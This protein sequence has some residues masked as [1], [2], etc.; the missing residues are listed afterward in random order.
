VTG[1]PKVALV[2]NSRGANTIRNYVKNGGGASVVS[3]VVLGGG[4]IT[5][6]TTTRQSCRTSN[7]TAPAC[8]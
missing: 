4:V 5:A 1:A 2:G 8:S 3:H 6:S 7:S